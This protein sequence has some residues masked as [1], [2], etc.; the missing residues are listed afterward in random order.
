[1]ENSRA[2]IPAIEAVGPILSERFDYPLVRR[3]RA[4]FLHFCTKC[5]VI[6][7]GFMLF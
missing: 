7:N 4:F 6:L 2:V 3:A 1:M 5:T